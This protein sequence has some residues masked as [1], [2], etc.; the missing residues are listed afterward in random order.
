M[1]R[2][3]ERKAYY[4]IFAVS[5]YVLWFLFKFGGVPNFKQAILSTTIDVTLCMISL[6][7]AVEFL[8]PKFIYRGAYYYFAGFYS[9]LIFISGSTIISLQLMLSGGSIF[10]YRANLIKHHEHFF[11]WFWSDLVFGSFFLVTF[12]SL[13]GCSIRLAFDR[14][15]AAKKMETLEKEKLVSELTMLKNQINPHFLFNALNTVYYKIDKSNTSARKILEQFS[16]LLRY[17]LYECNVPFVAIEKEIEFLSNYVE[18]QSQRLNG[19]CKIDCVGFD[20]VSGFVISPY[21]LIPLVENC[22][23]HVSHLPGNSNFIQINCGCDDKWFWLSTENSIAK[24]KDE[25]GSGIGLANI[26]K[27][28][29]LLY[30]EKHDLSIDQTDDCFRLTLKLEVSCN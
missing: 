19:N 21:L 17:Q 4:L 6:L 15:V 12:I 25:S 23:K 29:Q 2:I 30:P 10:S 13:L 28:L 16:S 11:Y 26:Q 18:V 1:M 20:K 14:I 24:K 7:A 9:L 3:L 5:F 27:R 8:L 22:F